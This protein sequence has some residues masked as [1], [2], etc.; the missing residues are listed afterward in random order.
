M[1]SVKDNAKNLVAE[2]EYEPLACDPDAARNF[3]KIAVQ[4][5]VT[6][7]KQAPYRSPATNQSALE[8]TY[9]Y[10]HRAVKAGVPEYRMEKYFYLLRAY[11]VPKLRSTDAE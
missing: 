6:F 3:K 2:L 9:I 8:S 1:L 7:L 10:I 5:Y 4:D 11:W